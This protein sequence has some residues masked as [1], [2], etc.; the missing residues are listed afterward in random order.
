MAY[1]RYRESLYSPLS[2]AARHSTGASS[3]RSNED[4]REDYD[5]LELGDLS[6]TALLNTT[7]YD[8]YRGSSRTSS[9]TKPRSISS[10]SA[11]SDSTFKTKSKAFFERAKSTFR[12]SRNVSPD[13]RE[14]TRPGSGLWTELMLVDRT[15]RG[16]AGL[17]TLFAVI[18]VVIC[19][20]YAKRFDDHIDHMPN[21]TSVRI[22]SGK[23]SAMNHKAEGFKFLINV[24]ATMILGMSNTYQQLLTALKVDDLKHVLY[25]A[26]DADGHG[27]PGFC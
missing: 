10:L 12:I 6:N 16:M 18:M 15:L 27:S 26:K 20:A 19:V 7:S 13:E 22:S 17:T 14:N 8:P 25:N 21:S 9:S 11:T 5:K 2:P 3:Y 24:A 1:R 23:R 4:Q